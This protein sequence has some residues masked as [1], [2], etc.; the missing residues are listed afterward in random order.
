MEKKASELKQGDWLN[1]QKIAW[2]IS[3]YLKSGLTEVKFGDGTTKFFGVDELV[4]VSWSA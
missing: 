4:A 3:N 2:V 1:G